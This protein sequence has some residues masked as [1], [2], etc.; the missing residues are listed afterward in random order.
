MPGALHF[1]WIIPGT[2]LVLVLALFYYAFCTRLPQ[3][4]NKL[5]LWAAVLFLGGCVGFEM[6]G[7]YYSTLHGEMNLAYSSLTTGEE[8]LELAGLV[9]FIRALLEGLP[10]GGAEPSSSRD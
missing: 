9:L 3:P 1:A 5:A 8:S 6:I 7:G 10:G 2:L 4:M